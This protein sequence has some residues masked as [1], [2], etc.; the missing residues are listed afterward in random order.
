MY[1][2]MF[3]SNEGGG[4]CAIAELD[5]IHA[6]SFNFQC[7]QVFASL[8]NKQE[9]FKISAIRTESFTFSLISVNE[10]LNS[11]LT[12]KAVLNFELI[13]QGGNL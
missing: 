2:S 7:Q 3:L 8:T 10:L 1:G 6:I 5:I 9:I 11:A 4:L 13:G 12:R